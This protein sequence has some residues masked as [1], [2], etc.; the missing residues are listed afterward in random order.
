MMKYTS[1]HTRKTL[2]ILLLVLLLTAVSCSTVLNVS[3]WEPSTSGISGYKTVAVR[4]TT[5]YAGSVRSY[6]MFVGVNID[7]LLYPVPV[8]ISHML[9]NVDSSVVRKVAKTAN[10]VVE[11]ALNQGVY[12]VYNSTA[13]EGMISL[14]STSGASV[15]DVLLRN[16]VEL[17]V[18]SKIEYMDY[19]EYITLESSKDKYGNPSGY[20]YY[21]NQEAA[22]TM[23]CMVQDVETL[24]I[25]WSRTFTDR[26]NPRGWYTSTYKTRIGHIDLDG[27]FSWVDYSNVKSVDAIFS[28]MVDGFYSEIR[29]ALTPHRIYTSFK[30]MD[31]KAKVETIKPAYGYAND[32]LY[33]TALSLFLDEWDR[34]AYIP[35]GY[36][37][38]VIYFAMGKYTETTEMA[39]NVYDTTGSPDALTLM[40]RIG[41]LLKSQQAAL[42]QSIGEKSGTSVGTDVIL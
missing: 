21:L 15:R 4:T 39:R 2:M 24:S 32:G 6:N 28:S 37:A 26:T 36:N 29:N 8:D 10:S 7:P 13:T 11:N 33:T 34:S 1:R 17:L 42:D 5:A 18:T 19:D 23:S 20:N 3:T 31:N 30:L 14:A 41:S 22:L 40:S 25:L 16:G 38:A 35:A 12:T 27:T 9:S